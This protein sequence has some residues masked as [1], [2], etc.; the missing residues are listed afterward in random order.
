MGKSSAPAWDW[1]S[2]C[3]L[4]V[5]IQVSAARLVTTDW[6]PFLY[7]AETLSG[8]GIV[9]G[10][11]LGASHFGRRAVAELAVA[12]TAFCLPWQLSAA[13]SEKDFLARLSGWG[14]ILLISLNQFLQRQPV[15]DSL[16]FVSFVCVVFWIISLAAGYGLARHGSV[17][18]SIVL[19][20][21]AIIIVQAYADYQLHSSWWLAIYLVLALLLAGRFHYLKRLE[22]WSRRRV[23]INED[24]WSDILGSLFLTVTAA[25]LFAWLVPTSPASWQGAADTWNSISH[26]IRERLSNAVS[27]LNGP[28]GPARPRV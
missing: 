28:Y 23:L 9:L 27:S 22:D 21:A 6:A 7:F 26:P 10:L 8:Y 20:G 19:G 4:F 2:A 16:F 18:A 13:V 17:L 5:L 14:E 11:A 25:V 1:L 15:R 24:S 3:L 12:Y